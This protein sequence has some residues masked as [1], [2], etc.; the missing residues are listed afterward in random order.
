L[1]AGGRD[2]LSG[3]A[4]RARQEAEAILAEDRFHESEL[5]RPLHGLLEWLG[6]L[7][8]PVVDAL[9]SVVPGGDA[10][11]WLVLA[12]LVLA[13]AFAFGLWLVRGRGPGVP[14]RRGGA[15]APAPPDAATLE[16]EADAAERAGDLEGALR[17]RFRAGVLRLAERHV[18][19]NPS[20]A[21]SGALARR[22]GSQR[23]A[24][25][26]AAF[27]EV[28]YGRRPPTDDDVQLAREGWRSVLA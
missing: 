12:L 7:L 17:L 20:A 22:L 3:R 21:T 1:E 6:D 4:E 2:T 25:A 26:A 8:E 27:D 28:V 10:G 24:A 11:L 19:H 23:F 13:G 18:V 16:R 14:R 15:E 9:A 5:P